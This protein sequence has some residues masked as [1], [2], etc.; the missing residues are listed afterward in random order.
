MQ[1]GRI[2]I[3]VIIIVFISTMIILYGGESIYYQYNFEKPVEKAFKSMDEIKDIKLLNKNHRLNL[4]LELSQIDNLQST[5][6]EIQSKAEKIFGT[7]PFEII[8][9]NKVDNSLD[10]VFYYIQFDI[11]EAI[12]KGD[13]SKMITQ[14]EKKSQQ[15]GVTSKVYID[16]DNLYL[17]M[18]HK[19][20]YLYKIFPRHKSSENLDRLKVDEGG[21]T[22]NG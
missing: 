2:K 16:N 6:T 21:S 9:S 10:N 3:P 8:I 18:E 19:N 4:Q 5:Y 7:K 11:F 14:I 15:A 17:Q 1:F 12:E 22:K 20:N 13:Y